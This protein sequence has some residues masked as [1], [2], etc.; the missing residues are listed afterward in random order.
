MRRQRQR[1]FT[2]VEIMVVAIIIVILITMAIPIYQKQVI[3]SR[4]AV[5]KSNLFTLRVSI[6]QYMFDRQMA[7]QALNNLVDGGFLTQVPIDPI[8]GV[9]NTWK[10]VQEDGANGMNPGAAGIFD[11][12]SGS[13]KIA[14]DGTRYA[15][16]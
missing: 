16:W 11:V 6:N 8:T 1:G 5:L 7:P 10:T 12:H 3:R 2:F 9:N 4:E 13:N 14:L 15:D